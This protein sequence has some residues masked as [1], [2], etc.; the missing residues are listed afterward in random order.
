MAKYIMQVE[1]GELTADE[2]EQL[3]FDNESLKTG[4]RVLLSLGVVEQPDW[5]KGPMRIGDYGVIVEEDVNDKDLPF[6]VTKT[7]YN[8]SYW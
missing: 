3:I 4:D 1:A 5:E 7:G 2:A 6:K 8:M